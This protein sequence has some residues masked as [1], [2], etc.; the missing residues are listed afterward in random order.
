MRPAWAANGLRVR[1]VPTVEQGGRLVSSEAGQKLLYT[2]DEANVHHGRFAVRVEDES[3]LHVRGLSSAQMTLMIDGQIVHLTSS[4]MQVQPIYLGSQ[5]LTLALV[6]DVSASMQGTPLAEC[7]SRARAVVEALGPADRL[8]VISFSDVVTVSG[9]HTGD[10]DVLRLFVNSLQAEQERDG[11]V[12][13]DALAKAVEAM[14][15]DADQKA[16]LLF[17]DGENAGSI[18][19]LDD[20]VKT[21]AMADCP[22]FV[23]GVGQRRVMDATLDRIA[24][25]TGGA[26][27]TL[28]ASAR[29]IVQ[30]IRDA[31]RP[32]YVVTIRTDKFPA[33]GK[34]HELSVRVDVEDGAG[35]S[36][37]AS[38]L[39]G[40][41]PTRVWAIGIVLLALSMLVIVSGLALFLATRRR[42]GLHRAAVDAG[43][44]GGPLCPMCREPMPNSGA[45]CPSCGYEPGKVVS[46]DDVA[47]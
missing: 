23:L 47:P 8:A 33:D 10:K 36:E 39:S 35:T 30:K 11:S 44:S 19:P 27:L 9:L 17:A 15:A 24:S 38:F 5:G 42:A 22:V 13:A 4:E 41:E 3:G 34:S 32:E 6:Q 31:L 46:V 29:E 43:K 26:R 45:M 40:L 37:A 16:V 7:K 1:L 12:L 18:K 14:P 2:F 25:G 28:A 21:A 20:A